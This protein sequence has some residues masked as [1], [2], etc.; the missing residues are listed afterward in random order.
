[1]EV[2]GGGGGALKLAGGGLIPGAPRGGRHGDLADRRLLGR[3][4]HARR[5]TSTSY[6]RLAAPAGNP[7]APRGADRDRWLARRA[8]RAAPVRHEWRRGTGRH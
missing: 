1:M 4:R 6:R 5:P 7:S 2:Q 8:V 3:A